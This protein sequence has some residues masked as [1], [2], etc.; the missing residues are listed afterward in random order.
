MRNLL[1]LTLILVATTTIHAQKYITKT[2]MI[3]FYSET[4]MEKIEAVN[5]QVAAALDYSSGDF[6]FKV[7]MKSFEFPKALM[8]EHFNENYVESDKFPDAKYVGKVKNINELKIDKDGLYPVTVEGQLT[9]H[10]ITKPLNAKGTFEVK[11]G[12]VNGKSKF[13][14]QP[15]DYNINIPAAVIKNIAKSIE[16]TVDINLAPAGK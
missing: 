9:M 13:N 4:P 11:L 7:L 2:G 8:Q 10:G 6:I 14:V 15:S 1:I 12:K 5:K 16:I 3:R